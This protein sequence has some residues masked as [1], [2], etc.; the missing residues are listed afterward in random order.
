MTTFAI[1]I[2]T[3][4]TTHSAL[5]VTLL[6]FIAFGATV[7]FS[8]IA[9]AMVARWNRRVNIIVSDVGSGVVTLLLLVAYLFGH[10]KLWR[11]LVGHILTVASLAS[12][13]PASTT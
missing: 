5:N 4:Q 8:P 13:S 2:A 7:L 6:T 10:T 12:Q 3:Y 9:G 11:L 1:A